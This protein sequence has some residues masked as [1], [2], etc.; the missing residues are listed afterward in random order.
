MIYL[1]YCMQMLFCSLI[2]YKYILFFR[3][4]VCN[5]RISTLKKLDD[6]NLDGEVTEVVFNMSYNE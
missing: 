4:P 6:E 1:S 2:Q 5:R 3:E